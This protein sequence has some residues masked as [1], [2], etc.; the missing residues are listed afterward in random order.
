MSTLSAAELRKYE[1]RIPTFLE[2]LSSGT[3]LNTSNSE[4]RLS[5]TGE[6]LAERLRNS[7][8]REV[9]K[10]LFMGD[11]GCEY[12]LRDLLKDR[13]FGGGSVPLKREDAALALIR[14]RLEIIKHNTASDSIPVVIGSE[15]YYVSDVAT[16]PGTPKSDFHFVSPTGDELVWLSHKHGNSPRSFQ[17]WGGCSMRNEPNI[18][19]HEE[20]QAFAEQVRTLS[21]GAGSTVA[22]L[23]QDANLQHLAVYGNDYGKEFG[24]NNVQLVIQ[25]EPTLTSNT[26]NSHF[27]V[28]AFGVHQNG[29]VLPTV[30]RPSFMAMYR[31]DRNDFGIKNCRVGISP[32]NARLV[33]EWIDN[34]DQPR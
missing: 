14:Q 16:T 31:T 18:H 4:I 21:F 3:F 2:R 15:C 25:G 20:T 33:K 28:R 29:E 1:W 17:Q 9:N 13:G 34:D 22:K 30:Y 5:Y 24:Q 7:P 6:D 12:R 23:I 11:D 27:D 10:I 19:R 32:K 26:S 8:V